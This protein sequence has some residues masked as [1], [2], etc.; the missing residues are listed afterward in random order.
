MKLNSIDLKNVIRLII[1]NNLELGKKG[2]FTCSIGVTG[3]P[4]IGKTSSIRQVANELGMPFIKLSLSQNTVEDIVGFP[5]IEHM[6]CR[7]EGT[8][9]ECN[10]IH[11]KALDQYITNGWTATGQS[12]TNW[13]VPKWLA[14]YHDTDTAVILCLDDF[15]RGSGALIAA[16]MEI[17][18]EQMYVSWSLPAGSTVITSANPDDGENLVA[19]TDEAQQT[20]K[21]EYEMKFDLNTWINE[22]AIPENIDDRAIDFIRIHGTEV[23]GIGNNMDNNGN[24]LKKSNIRLWTKYFKVLQAVDNWY[25]KMDQVFLLAGSNFPEAHIQLFINY[26]KKLYESIPTNEEVMDLTKNMSVVG[27]LIE[28]SVK[29]SGGSVRA[30]IASLFYTRLLTHTLMNCDGFSKDQTDRVRDIILHGVNSHCM[31]M[32]LLLVMLKKLT[33]KQTFLEDVIN[34]APGDA[35]RAFFVEKKP[36]VKQ[37][38][39]VNVEESPTEATAAKPKTSKKAPK[40]DS[41]E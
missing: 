13:A 9:E 1:A 20:R 35:I 10:W 16:C 12:R 18:E 28:K 25:E 8:A 15:S 19:S 22:F 39:V 17:C 4:G 32:D 30:D 7:G 33:E 23:I 27:K 14:P 24:K 34:N 31:H 29:N 2:E 5:Y 6:V 11:E 21:L 38:D 3:V 36:S 26:L 40:T 41:N 37:A